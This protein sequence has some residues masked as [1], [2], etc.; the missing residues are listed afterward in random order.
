MF[1]C[2]TCKTPMKP[3]MTSWFCP[4]DC[5]RPI[6]AQAREAK[7]GGREFSYGTFLFSVDQKFTGRMWSVYEV[8]DTSIMGN[9][10]GW[11]MSSGRTPDRWFV[12][13]N[14][15]HRTSGLLGDDKV[16]GPGEVF[17][18]VSAY[19]YKLVVFIPEEQVDID[20]VAKEFQ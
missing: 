11:W 15:T 2:T 17:G 1:S 12:T 9:W 5:D 6:L 14:C 7:H 19:G 10:M 4:K 13:N 16:F 8:T 20:L 3:L 18:K